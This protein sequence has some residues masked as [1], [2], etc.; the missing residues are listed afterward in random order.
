[1]IGPERWFSLMDELG[2]LW[3][4]LP[5]FM[6]DLYNEFFSGAPDSKPSTLQRCVTENASATRDYYQANVD[7]ALRLKAKFNPGVK[8]YLSVW[9]HFMCAQ[10]VSASNQRL[11]SSVHLQ[12]S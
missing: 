5:V 12:T 8:V 2:W 4:E 9:W 7:E 6:P 3:A 11:P 10:E 1:M